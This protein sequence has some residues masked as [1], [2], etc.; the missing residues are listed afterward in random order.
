MP[1]KGLLYTLCRQKELTAGGFLTYQSMQE[2]LP[3]SGSL[4]GYESRI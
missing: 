3:V 1:E 4:I 2:K